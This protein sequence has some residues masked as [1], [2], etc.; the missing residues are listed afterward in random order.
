MSNAIAMQNPAD[1]FPIEFV[2]AA[3][4]LGRY[5]STEADAQALAAI[6]PRAQFPAV[7]DMCCGFGRMAGM[8]HRLGYDV[9]GV[10]LSVEQIELALHDNPGPS[11]QVGDMRVLP[12]NRSYDAIVNLFTSFG[13]FETVEEDLQALRSWHAGLRPG[14]KLVME[15]A[16]MEIARAKLD[17]N[18]GTIYR[19]TGNVVEECVM[20]WEQQ[21]FKVKYLQEGQT[22]TCYTRLYEKEVLRDHLL[23]IGFSDVQLYGGLDLRARRSTDNLVLIAT[24]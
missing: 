1:G 2:N 4:V 17:R 5:E 12:K 9:T 10:D 21:I 24:K 14:G 6:I 8:L 11:Y 7:L 13:Y 22:F 23:E 18:A 3:R 15:L 20:D 19:H 16:D